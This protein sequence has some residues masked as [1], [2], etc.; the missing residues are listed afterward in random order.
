MCW[1]TLILSNA[2]AGNA[3]LV[4]WLTLLAKHD[5]AG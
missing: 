2:L 1:S 3:M 4:L 5:L